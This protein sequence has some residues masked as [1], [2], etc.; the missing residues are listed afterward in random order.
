MTLIQEI[1]E[2]LIKVAYKPR[3]KRQKRQ[4]GG[5]R[6]KSRQYYRRNRAQIRKR[7]TRYRKKYRN[8]LKARRRRP[9]YKRVG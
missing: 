2:L 9:S 8:L 7:M 5:T 4:R 6:V 1:E 3:I